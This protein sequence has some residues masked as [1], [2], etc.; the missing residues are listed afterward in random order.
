MMKI[1]RFVAVFF[2]IALCG[3]AAKERREA[4]EAAFAGGDVMAGFNAVYKDLAGQSGQSNREKALK[5]FDVSRRAQLDE[6]FVGQIQNLT[7][8]ARALIVRTDVSVAGNAGLMAQER[9]AELRAAIHER[10]VAQIAAG[11][12]QPT[13]G[14]LLNELPV[15]LDNPTVAPKAVSNSLVFL[16]KYQ[17]SKS[18]PRRADVIALFRYIA[19]PGNKFASQV[20]VVLPNIVFSLRELKYDVAPLFRSFAE[21]RMEPMITDTVV[22]SSRAQRLLVVDL[23]NRLSRYEE[24][25]IVDSPEAAEA[26]VDVDEVQYRERER[27]PTVR[28]I[29]VPPNEVD[30]YIRPKHVP[31]DSAFIY[32]VEESSFELEWAYEVRVEMKGGPRDSDVVRGTE[33]AESH[34]CVSFAFVTPAGIVVPHD[35]GPNYTVRSFC[36]N[37]H[38]PERP[39]FRPNILDRLADR[40]FAL[41]QRVAP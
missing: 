33:R 14:E 41:I 16:G 27:G 26:I 22:L 25:R 10:L 5:L 13:V 17:P 38:P 19:T 21:D 7:T 40:T 31:E 30:G 28:H 3:C 8:I 36:D 35:R 23:T 2:L 20:E 32:D 39:D 1:T 24:I 15:V 18:G 37:R 9:A 6:A 34:E 4:A 11:A 29:A 12:L